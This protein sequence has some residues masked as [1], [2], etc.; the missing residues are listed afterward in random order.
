MPN[1]IQPEHQIGPNNAG[2][3]ILRGCFM[4]VSQDWVQNHS[5]QVGGLLTRYLNNRLGEATEI[6]LNYGQS[7]PPGRE[8]GPNPIDISFMATVIAR[9]RTHELRNGELQHARTEDISDQVDEQV[10]VLQHE[11]GNYLEKC[12]EA[13]IEPMFTGLPN[14]IIEN[15]LSRTAV[16]HATSLNWEARGEELDMF[17]GLTINEDAA[18]SYKPPTP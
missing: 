11:I 16:T 13:D 18:S 10:M 6:S 7:I 4:N 12:R 2:K 5:G 9:L 14:V 1:R 15:V 8:N 3:M 17:A